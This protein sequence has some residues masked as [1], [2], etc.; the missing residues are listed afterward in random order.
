MELPNIKWIISVMFLSTTNSNFYS[1]SLCSTR[2]GSVMAVDASAMAGPAMA[3]PCQCHCSAVAGATV[4]SRNP[5]IA[6][7]WQTI[8]Y[9]TC[10]PVG[11]TMDTKWLG[12]RGGAVLGKIT[13]F[14]CVTCNSMHRAPETLRLGTGR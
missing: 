9:I 11:L 14:G 6:P 5:M 1:R 3:I 10:I 7:P 8:R 12:K 2:A 4:V 13:V